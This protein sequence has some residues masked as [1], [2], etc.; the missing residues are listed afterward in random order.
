MVHRTWKQ[1]E[2][3]EIFRFCGTDNKAVQYSD[4]G[5]PSIEESNEGRR[6]VG[7]RVYSDGRPMA[8]KTDLLYAF[9]VAGVRSTK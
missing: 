3:T 6:G 1:V 9:G 5:G 8:G 2:N 4:C 7:I